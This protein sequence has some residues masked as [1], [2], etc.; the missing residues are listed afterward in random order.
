MSQQPSPSLKDKVIAFYDQESA[1]YGELY[2]EPLDAQEFYP[3]NAVRLELILGRLK[4][5]G[6][7]RV[8]DIG[9][10][11][12]QPLLRLL[13]EGF[14]A[15]GFDFSSGMVESA[16]TAL[17][18]GGE[19]PERV[20]CADLEKRNT[21]LAGPFDAIVATG[22]FPHNL[23][24]V[25][26]YANLRELLAPGGVAF[27][28]YRNALLSLFSLNR[29]CAPFFWETLVRGDDL[30]P[31]LREETR[32]FLAKKFDTPVESVGHRREIEFSDILARFHNP[33]TLPHEISPHGIKI[34]RLHYYHWHAAPPH[35][36]KT[37]RDEFWAASLK[38][39]RSD[40]WRGMFL[41][42]AFVAEIVRG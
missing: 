20:T 13:R 35:I 22:V 2:T 3:A 39:E 9:C 4:E 30:P 40:D 19:D 36:E 12:G 37:H 34:N 23:D 7:K 16:R 29:Y 32:A 31:A 18:K 15:R 27:V 41:C 8:L 11:S 14:D 6:A 26:A 38:L 28:E 17:Q 10:G 33:L 42:S 1:R 25:A 5:I 24:D 21:L